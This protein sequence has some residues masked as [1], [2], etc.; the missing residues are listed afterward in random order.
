MNQQGSNLPSGTITPVIISHARLP[1]NAGH[2]GTTS[3]GL[4][5]GAITDHQPLTPAGCV[6]VHQMVMQQSTQW[7]PDAA[8]IVDELHYVTK[9]FNESEEAASQRI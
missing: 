8:R 5:A 7:S 3:V 9:K 4:P 1:Q 6:M 2:L